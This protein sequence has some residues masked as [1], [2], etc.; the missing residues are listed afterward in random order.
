MEKKHSGSFIGDSFFKVRQ[1]STGLFR[2]T[3][4]RSSRW[5]EA[6]KVYKSLAGARTSAQHCPGPPADIEV[7][8]F[9]AVEIDTHQPRG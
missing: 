9:R 1:I 4:Y 6:G 3:A 5:E 8:E 2:M 7:V